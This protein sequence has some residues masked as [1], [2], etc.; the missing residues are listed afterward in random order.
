M[1]KQQMEL[2]LEQPLGFRRVARR[3][4]RP[5]RARWWFAQMRQVVANAAEPAPVRSGET[6][7]RFCEISE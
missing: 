5:T 6:Q 7:P 2:G 4:R 3:E 1:T